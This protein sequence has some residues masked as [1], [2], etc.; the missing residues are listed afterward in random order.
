MIK[1]R[2][3]RELA[4]DLLPRSVCAVQAAAVVCDAAGYIIS[5]GWNSVGSGLGIHAERHAINRSNQHR[6]WYGTIYVASQRKRNEK[7]IISKP[8]PDCER[9]IKKWHLETMYRDAGDVW[10]V[11]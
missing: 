8:C 6:L 9:I 5:W 11:G 10:R 3:P 7:T 2:D 1:P 4:V